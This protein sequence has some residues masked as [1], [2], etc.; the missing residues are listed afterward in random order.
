MNHKLSFYL[1]LIFNV[2]PIVGVAF[3]DWSPFE[4]FWLFWMETLMVAVFNT[5]RVLFSQD[6]T[7]QQAIN[8]PPLHINWG[9][10]LRYFFGRIF[11]FLFYSIFIIV[12]IGFI[13]N[14]RENKAHV[15]QTVLLQNTIFNIALLLMLVSQAT[16]LVKQFIQNGRYLLA[17]PK[18]F[19]I[20]FDSRQIVIHIAVILGSVGSVFLFNHGK[21]S[22]FSSIWII[23]V[24]CIL[25]CFWEI[26]LL[27]KE[28]E[29]TYP[30]SSHL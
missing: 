3:Y 18:Q 25:K 27:S 9:D 15:F 26:R 6:L 19:P 10:G 2:F 5:F 11:I 23:G 8:H 16:I 7:P 21:S 20:F 13:S 30:E 17:S 29:T 14:A 24:F 12:F 28:V 4:M 1:I 22:G